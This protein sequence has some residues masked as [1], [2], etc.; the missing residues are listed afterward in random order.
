MM[1]MNSIPSSQCVDATAGTNS[2][3]LFWITST[4]F[5]SVMFNINP[6]CMCF[7]LACTTTANPCTKVRRFWIY[8][9]K[10]K[11]KNSASSRSDEYYFEV[12]IKLMNIIY[13]FKM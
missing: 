4:F 10:R 13:S 7:A 12:I 2:E 6:Y 1:D 8:N 9:V 11:K 5:L 3:L